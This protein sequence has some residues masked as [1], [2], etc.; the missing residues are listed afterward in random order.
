AVQQAGS[1]YSESLAAVRHLGC[2]AVLLVGDN[3]IPEPLPPRTAV[4]PYAPFSKILPRASVVVHP[5]GIGTTAQALAAGRPMLVVPYSYDQPDDAARVERLRV[6]RAVSRKDYEAQR[7]T[8]EV[9]RLL[10]DTS[11]SAA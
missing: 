2:R 6:A 10:S 3:S 1:F 9:D 8:E 5:G 7:L 4:F 11:Y